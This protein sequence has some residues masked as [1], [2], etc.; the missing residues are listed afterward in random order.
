MLEYFQ[1]AWIEC[2]DKIVEDTGEEMP[3]SDFIKEYMAVWQ[4]FLR[5]EQYYRPGR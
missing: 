2:C 1:C 4:E 5:K 3:K